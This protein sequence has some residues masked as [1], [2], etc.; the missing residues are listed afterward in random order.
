MIHQ[1]IGNHGDRRFP[2]PFRATLVEL[3]LTRLL[4]VADYPQEIQTAG[5]TK[6]F[7]DGIRALPQGKPNLEDHARALLKGRV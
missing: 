1:T 5:V 6:T 4:F 3:Y 7:I 2:P